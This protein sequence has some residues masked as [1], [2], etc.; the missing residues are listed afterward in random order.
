MTDCTSFEAMRE[1]G[2]AQAFSYDAHLKAAG[3]STIND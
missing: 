1:M 2:V 3:F